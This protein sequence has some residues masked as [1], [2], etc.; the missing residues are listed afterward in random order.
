MATFAVHKVV[1]TL[2]GT[3]EPNTF[4]AVRVGAGF[5]LY[6]SDSTG[7]VAH[8]HNDAVGSG[9]GGATYAVIQHRENS[10][11]DGGWADPPSAQ[12]TLNHVQY[13]NITGLSL[14]SNYVTLPAGTYLLSGWAAFYRT[15]DSRVFFETI[16]NA[17]LVESGLAHS[18]F[19]AGLHCPI[20]GVFTLASE[21]PCRL[22][23]EVDESQGIEDLGISRSNFGEDEVHVSLTLTKIA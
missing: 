9:G 14:A 5:D 19:N 16:T 8:K 18:R 22:W 3:L 2:P 20:D 6:L 17:T 1:A 11:V 10:G 4:Y 21:M 12:R 15:A 13:S 7:S 23:Y